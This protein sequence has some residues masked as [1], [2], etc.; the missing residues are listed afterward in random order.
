MYKC[1]LCNKQFKY[2]SK[3]NEHNN[4]KSPCVISKNIYK[5]DIC[6]YECPYISYLDRHKK[7]KKCIKNTEIHNVTNNITNINNTNITNNNINNIINLTI[8]IN[9]FDNTNLAFV[10]PMLVKDIVENQ[11]IE[12]LAIDERYIKKEQRI[13]KIMDGIIELLQHV[14]FN[15]G[16]S[17]NHNCKILLVFP[18]TNKKHYEYLILE[19][20]S[21]DNK[22][23]WMQINY[24]GF[25]NEIMRLMYKISDKLPNPDFVKTLEY[26][27]EN[28]INNDTIKLNIKVELEIKLNTL[29]N[30]FDKLMFSKE[31]TKCEKNDDF[32]KR[33][34]LYKTYREERCRLI[35]GFFPPVD[36]TDI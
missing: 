26:I 19:L 25:L 24:D 23:R 17:E 20:K 22:L 4:R 16:I 5:C 3:L 33:L 13:L 35:N 18:D 12:Y 29:Y 31:R 14:N 1:E 30:N 9:T 32:F 2:H 10:R 8:N 34:E 28:L 7:S 21:E 6:H 15:M 11:F 27:N 36:G